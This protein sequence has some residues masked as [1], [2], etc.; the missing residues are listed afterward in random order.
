MFNYCFEVYIYNIV[1]QVIIIDMHWLIWTICCNCLNMDIQYRTKQILV[2][3]YLS[4]Y[5][6]GKFNSDF[7]R[8]TY[9]FVFLFVPTLHRFFVIVRAKNNYIFN[10]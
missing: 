4:W 3:R 1:L 5:E 8:P 2:Y 7:M 10:I 6:L 9:E